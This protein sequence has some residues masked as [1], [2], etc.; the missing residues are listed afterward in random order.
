MAFPLPLGSSRRS[1]FPSS[2]L[3]TLC[4]IKSCTSIT[5][6][7]SN[8][9]GHQSHHQ[10]GPSLRSRQTKPEAALGG[11]TEGRCREQV[12]FA[13]RFT[14]S[15]NLSSATC[16]SQDLPGAGFTRASFS[17]SPLVFAHVRLAD[18]ERTWA[19]TYRATPLRACT[20]LLLPQEVS[21]YTARPNK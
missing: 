5:K 7:G 8:F 17:I 14:Q 13:N 6:G 10:T 21:T 1:P 18:T 9:S 19:F 15:K 2:S 20:N 12:W 4:V 16:I 3:G 11:Q